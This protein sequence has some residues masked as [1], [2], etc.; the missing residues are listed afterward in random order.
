MSGCGIAG[1]FGEGLK[2]FR[3]GKRC[4]EVWIGATMVIRM[5]RCRDG[6]GE[7]S[8]AE[9]SEKLR[10]VLGLVVYQTCDVVIGSCFGGGY[11][12]EFSENVPGAFGR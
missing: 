6:C 7:E 11:S 9:R 8:L 5:M 12:H 3:A 4:V 1:E 10:W 2:E